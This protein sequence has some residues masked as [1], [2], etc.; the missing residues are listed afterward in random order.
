VVVIFVF[1]TMKMTTRFTGRQKHSIPVINLCPPAHGNNFT[2]LTVVVEN[3]E[4]GV[5][6]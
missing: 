3:L 1:V 6:T 2:I 5:I 4:H